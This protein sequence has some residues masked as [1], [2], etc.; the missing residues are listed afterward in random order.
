LTERRP[1]LIEFNVRAPGLVAI[2]THEDPL[3]SDLVFG[4]LNTHSDLMSP[5]N[6]ASIRAQI[7]KLSEM[8]AQFFKHAA[9]IKLTSWESMDSGVSP[10]ALEMQRQASVALYPKD[11]LK[12]KF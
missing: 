7:A 11:H 8:S 12:V 3:S 2:I 6:V 9:K 4:A 10:S 1:D 5:A